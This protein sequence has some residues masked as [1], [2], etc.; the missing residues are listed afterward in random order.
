MKLKRYQKWLLRLPLY[1]ILAAF[2]IA[3]LTYL[4][5]ISGGRLNAYLADITPPER[6]AQNFGLIGAAF[7]FGFITGPAIGG[8]LGGIDLRLP[9]VVASCLSFANLGFGYFI[10]PESLAPEM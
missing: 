2:I 10:L 7:G 9:F 5:P 3:V 8:L 6:R 4:F 1:L